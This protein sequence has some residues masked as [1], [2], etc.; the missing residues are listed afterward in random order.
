M[1]EALSK[2]PGQGTFQNDA[3]AGSPGH[4]LTFVEASNSVS[5]A[6][7]EQGNVWQQWVFSLYG[8]I[9][10]D[11]HCLDYDGNMLLVFHCHKAHGNQEWMY[12]ATT[13]HFEHKKHKGKCL[14]VD[15]ALKKVRIDGCDLNQQS[16]R[17]H[18]PAIEFRV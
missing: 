11:N 18:Y 12:N 1:T 2:R 7:C 8:E 9:G 13:Y 10:T 14:D 16:Q 4:C 3:L 6:P 17:W 15:V 5:M